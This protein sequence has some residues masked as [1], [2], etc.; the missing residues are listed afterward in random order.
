MK[1]QLDMEMERDKP[2]SANHPT[3]HISDVCV[4]FLSEDTILELSLIAN[5]L[6]QIFSS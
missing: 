2:L 6:M 3:L 4:L 1:S 5:V